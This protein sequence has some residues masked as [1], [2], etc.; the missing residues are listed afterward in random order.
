MPANRGSL[1]FQV[2]R[3]TLTFGAGLILARIAG[4]VLVM[5]LARRLSVDEFGI[6][7]ILIAVLG[8]AEIASTAGIDRVASRDMA[9]DPAA[10]LARLPD[11]A[12]LAG[13]AG[14][15]ATAILLAGALATRTIPGAGLAMALVAATVVVVTLAAVLDGAL[16][17][18]QRMASSAVGLVAASAVSLAITVLAVSAGAGVPAVFAG[19][20]VGQA[21]RM[22]LLARATSSKSPLLR[23]RPQRWRAL[24]GE[25]APFAVMN[26]LGVLMFRQDVFLLGWLRGAREAAQYGAAFRFVEVSVFV[27]LIGFVGLGPALASLH[28]DPDRLWRVYVRIVAL[29]G[30]VGLAVSAVVFA[31]ADQLVVLVFSERYAPAASSLRILAWAILFYFVHMPALAVLL[32]AESLRG[33]VGLSVTTTA[34]SVIL[35]LVLIPRYGADGAALAA[36]ASITVGAGLAARLVRTVTRSGGV[37]LELARGPVPPLERG[38]RD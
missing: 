18:A 5:F 27:S 25:A 37:T 24:L 7:T 28:G 9:R 8:I 35:N 20:L 12:G 1:L 19:L 17:G 10:A 29:A 31:F 2:S 33:M 21:L 22:A 34:L 30:L 26:V 6:A 15:A 38:G 11:L 14:A 3:N 16:Q 36:A 4:L 32:Y 23:I 13:A